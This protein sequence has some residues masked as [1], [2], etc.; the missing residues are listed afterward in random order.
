MIATY[1]LNTKELSVKLI[2]LIRKTFPNKEI[3]ITITEQ[4]ATEYLKS[5]P[6]NK[7]HLNEAIQRIEKKQGLVDIDLKTLKK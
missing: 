2:E 6:A 4:D 3:E 7:K 1:K 5:N